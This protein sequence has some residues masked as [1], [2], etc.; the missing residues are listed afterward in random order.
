MIVVEISSGEIGGQSLVARPTGHAVEKPLRFFRGRTGAGS[1]RGHREIRH[2]AARSGEAAQGAAVGDFALEQS[3]DEFR[4]IMNIGG[5]LGGVPDRLVDF[6]CDVHIAIL[7]RSGRGCQSLSYGTY[8]LTGS[9]TTTPAG[10]ARWIVT[11]VCPKA[12]A[13][14]RFTVTRAVATVPLP[15]ENFTVTP[16]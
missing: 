9:T 2:A 12:P 16:S 6:D 5:A 13:F 8:Q 10:P 14:A 7:P 3:A 4:R 1:E 11:S 15:S